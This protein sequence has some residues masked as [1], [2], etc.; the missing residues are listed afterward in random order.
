[1]QGRCGTFDPIFWKANRSR[2]EGGRKKNN[3]KGKMKK[4]RPP[5]CFLLFKTFSYFFFGMHRLQNQCT[6]TQTKFFDNLEVFCENNGQKTFAIVEHYVLVFKT[7]TF[8]PSSTLGIWTFEECLVQIPALHDQTAVQIPYPG[9]YFDDQMPLPKPH[10]L[11]V[12]SHQTPTS[13][14]RKMVKCL[15]YMYAIRGGRG[16]C[17]RSEFIRA[18]SS[19]EDKIT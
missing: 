15:G 8:P 6:L 16:G 13:W 9:K 14:A 7:L 4:A 12:F 5:R 1:M 3:A 19:T 18:L 17:W 10:P 11:E 2:K